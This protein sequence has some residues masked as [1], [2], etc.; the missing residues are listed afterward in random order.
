ML[1]DRVQE[2]TGRIMRP[3]ERAIQGS[4][5]GRLYRPEIPQ[6]TG[7]DFAFKTPTD[8]Y[9]AMHLILLLNGYSGVAINH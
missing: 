1:G 8:L 4:T 6:P 7:T 3:R 5:M 2:S 9:T